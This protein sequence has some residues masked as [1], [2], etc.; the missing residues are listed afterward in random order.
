MNGASIHVHDL[1]WNLSSLSSILKHAF[2]F[3]LS[4]TMVV[5][6]DP[7]TQQH[8]IVIVCIVSPIVSSLFVIIRVWTRAFISHS[9]GLD[10]SKLLCP[11]PFRTLLSHVIE[12]ALVTWVKISYQSSRA[13]VPL[14]RLEQ[15]FCIAY[16]VL[17]GLGVF[18]GT[19]LP[20]SVTHHGSN[21]L[22]FWLA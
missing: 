16:S 12:A 17:I 2:A 11:L 14:M 3:R 5:N 7:S 18:P 15:L 21:E 8:A 19:S 13:V 9:I 6:T 20:S 1:D 10:D 22:W 4:C